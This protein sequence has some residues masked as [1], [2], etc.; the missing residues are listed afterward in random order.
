MSPS[1]VYPCRI[2]ANNVYSTSRGINKRERGDIH[3]ESLNRPCDGYRHCSI[4]LSNRVILLR[5]ADI[6]RK[7]KEKNGKSATG[8]HSSW[9]LA[10]P[11]GYITKAL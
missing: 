11:V 5:R 7:R 2:Y 1:A 8:Q 3:D 10:R 6:Q 4:E 9:R